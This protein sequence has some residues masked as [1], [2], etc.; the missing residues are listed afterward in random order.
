MK[1]TVVTAARAGSMKCVLLS[2]FLLSLLAASNAFAGEQGIA[3]ERGEW[4]GGRPGQLIRQFLDK[5]FKRHPAIFAYFEER[6][7]YIHL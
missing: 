2:C 3:F 1:N 6:S 7:T 5:E 4:S